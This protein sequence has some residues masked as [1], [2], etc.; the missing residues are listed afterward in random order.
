MRYRPR[1]RDR[2]AAI[3]IADGFLLLNKRIRSGFGLYYVIPG[4]GVDPGE[5]PSSAARREIEEETGLRVEIGREVFFGF[6]STGNRHSYFLAHTKKL[7]VALP[8]R[9]EENE[10]DRI[11]KRGTVQPQWAALR[12]LSKLRLLPPALK[13]AL[14]HALRFGFPRRPVEIHEVW[15][16][17]KHERSK[18]TEP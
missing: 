18:K 1:H 8:H 14:L 16:K 11:A 12:K 4:G 15:S 5:K 2:A 9:A 3:C 7:P 6:T 17:T 10:P 13:S